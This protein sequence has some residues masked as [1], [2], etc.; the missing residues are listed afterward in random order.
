MASLHENRDTIPPEERRDRALWAT[1]NV[2]VRV[3]IS[4]LEEA[5]LTR[6]PIDR[7]KNIRPISLNLLEYVTSSTPSPIKGG[8][9][10]F[11]KKSWS[12]RLQYFRGALHKHQFRAFDV[13]LDEVA[14]S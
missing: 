14:A 5:A 3:A 9:I 13:T 6:K 12:V 8:R 4:R 7:L 11:D 10:D 1:E 2:C